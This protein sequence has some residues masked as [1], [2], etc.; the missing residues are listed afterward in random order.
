MLERL[1]LTWE[2]GYRQV[3]LE[4]NNAL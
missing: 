3:E 2:K 1:R 4:S